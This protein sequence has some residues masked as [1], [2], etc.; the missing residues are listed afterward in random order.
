MSDNY[1]AAMDYLYSFVDY[2]TTRS[3]NAPANYDLRRM[4]ELLARLGNPHLAAPAVHVA[5]TKGKG[6][7][8]AMVASAL[9][10][11]GYR[12]GLYTSPH[13]IDLRERVRVDGRLI[14]KR[15]LMRLTERLRP[16]VEA[17][18]ARAA[19][20]RLTTFELLTALGFLYFAEEK[21]DFQVVE[22]GLGGRLDA[23]N[24]LHPQVAAITTLGLDHTDILGGTLTRI[25]GEKAGIIKQGIPVVSARQEAESLAVLKRVAREKDAQLIL[26]GRDIIVRPL[27]TGV[28]G[29]RLAVDGR[30][31]GYNISLPLL[32]Q[33][34]Q[35]NVAVAVGILEVLAERGFHVSAESIERGLGQVRWPGRFQVIRR[36]PLVIAD[37]AHNPAAAAELKKAILGYPWAAAHPRVLVVGSSA[38]KDYTGVAALLGPLF[39][40]VVVAKAR[41]P[42]A[43]DTGTLAA[44]F[45]P[46]SPRVEQADSVVP[47]LERAVELAG[48]GG[49]VCATGSLFLVGEALSWA[50]KRGY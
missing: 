30:L 4:D 35:E 25:A 8:A 44:A 13:L 17:V 21:A 27:K 48:P 12:T 5:G 15:D 11:A 6:S 20:G 29:Q 49:F 36:R 39:D 3:P 32:G 19:Y 47:A 33:Y 22:V 43:L 28:D 14:S 42:R 16:E 31:G 46:C 45:G 37:G 7:T 40:E 1:Q 10:A 24:V 50:H 9:M 18:N 2:E 34:Q 26:A 23:T 38:D 41:H